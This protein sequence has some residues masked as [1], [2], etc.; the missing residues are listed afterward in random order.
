MLITGTL[1]YYHS[2]N[3][4]HDL[5]VLSEDE[6]MFTDEMPVLGDAGKAQFLKDF[7][8]MVDDDYRANALACWK[9]AG[10]YVVVGVISI[11]EFA[12][13]NKAAK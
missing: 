13:H 1:F 8:A 12:R 9:V 7:Y 10:I 5:K 4:S 2:V 6:P 3:L 11:V